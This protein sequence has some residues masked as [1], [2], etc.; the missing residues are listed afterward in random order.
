VNNFLENIVAYE[1]IFVA[2]VTFISTFG[3]LYLKTRFQK[4]SCDAAFR[5]T[6]NRNSEIIFALKKLCK[7]LSADRVYIYE[8]HNG[9]YFS[10]GWPMQKFTCTYEYVRDG[11][12][13]ECENPGEYRISNY[14]EYIEQ[15]VNNKKFAVTDVANMKDNALLK[16]LLTTKGV[17]SMYNF[18]IMTLSDRTV[19]FLGVDFVSAPRSINEEQEKKIISSVKRISGYI[20]N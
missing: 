10:T 1:S 3:G 16:N 7:D 9:N 13:S 8:F 15:M 12:S 14:N 18:P 20:L 11:I 6:I 4:K 2:L 19:G 17:K 5:K